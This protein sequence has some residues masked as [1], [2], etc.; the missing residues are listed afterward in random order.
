[1]RLVLSAVCLFNTLGFFGQ[2]YTQIEVQNSAK[3][4]SME[5]S[6]EKGDSLIILNN[7]NVTPVHTYF[8]ENQT[9]IAFE[10]PELP[11]GWSYVILHKQHKTT[12]KIEFKETI[13]YVLDNN[14]NTWILF[15]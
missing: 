11:S 13:K 6:F 4:E 5:I 15:H 1:M 9:S 2:T 12:Y 10:V 8:L 3:I 14:Y 7:N